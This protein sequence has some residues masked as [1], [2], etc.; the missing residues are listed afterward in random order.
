VELGRLEGRSLQVGSRRKA[1][2]MK[3]D[4][5]RVQ[6][7]SFSCTKFFHCVSSNVCYTLCW[8][9][10]SSMSSVP[11][12]KVLR[13]L[14][15][16]SLQLLLAV[17]VS[18]GQHLRSASRHKPNI[19]RFRRSTFGIRQWRRVAPT[20]WCTGDSC[21]YFHKWLDTGGGGTVSRK[22]S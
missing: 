4:I 1:K 11:S 19:L 9:C 10:C 21:P 20:P 22:N 2:K 6:I 18:G 12:S 3:Q 15:L 8:K 7:L 13:R 17:P 5:K 16:A 14:L